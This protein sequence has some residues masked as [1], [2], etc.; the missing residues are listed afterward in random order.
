M[1]NSEETFSNKHL[2]DRATQ[3]SAILQLLAI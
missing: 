2:R 3:M 1:S